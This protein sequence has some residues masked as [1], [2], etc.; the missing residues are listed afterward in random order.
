MPVLESVDSW[1]KLPERGQLAEV[2]RRQW[3]VESV[4]QS[5]RARRGGGQHLVTLESIEEDALGEELRVVWEL[6]PG[7]RAFEKAGLPV[8]D[9]YDSNKSLDA[10]L[11]A[12]RWGAATNVDVDA[13]Q[14]PFRSGV[15]IYAHQLDPLVRALG[16]SR[17]NLLIA[18]DVGFG[19]TV[20][21]GLV[22]QELLLRHRAR[23]V[24][25]VCP[26]SLQIKWR[27]EMLDKFGLEFRVVNTEY[28][29]RLRR[30]RGLRVNP[31]TSYPR[32]ITSMDWAKQGEGLRLL[33]D[34]LPLNQTYPR[35]FDILIV[36]EAHNV[37]PTCS[38]S[39]QV[40]EPS[41]RTELIQRLSPHFNHKLFLT[42]TPHN[43]YQASFAALLELLDDQRFSR[44]VAPSPEKLSRVMTRR[45]KDEISRDDPDGEFQ[46][47]KREL[48]ALEI[49]YTD[50][51]R[52]IH[53]QLKEYTDLRLKSAA[54]GAAKTS[55]EFVNVLLKKRLFSSPRAFLNTLK[56]HRDTLLNPHL[57]EAK[58]PTERI[59]L[60]ALEKTESESEEERE[61]A[62][63]ELLEL[64]SRSVP[65]L[66]PDQRAIL[67]RLI[68]W[69]N[70]ADKGID[71]KAQAILDW[72]EKYIRPGGK[73]GDERV[74]LFTEYLDTYNWLAKILKDAKFVGK[75]GS[76]RLLMIDGSTDPEEREEIKA[77]FQAPPDKDPVR[78][79][80][81]TDAASE[82]IDLQNYC[83]Y[84]I[85]VE[86]PWNPNKME[87]R[88]GRIDRCG[89]KFK[90]VRIWHPVG[91]GFDPDAPWSK[92]GDIVGDGDF[93]ARVAIKVN[94]IR[95]DLGSVGAVVVQQIQDA[96]SGRSLGPLN[97]DG[98]DLKE[99]RQKVAEQLKIEKDVDAK[100]KRLRE[101]AEESR[102]AFR[103]GPGNIARAVDTAL[104]LAKFPPLE[105]IPVPSAKVG[106]VFRDVPYGQ[107]FRVPDLPGSWGRALAG[108]ADP[109][110]GERRPIVF[111]DQYVE[112][113]EDLVLAH[114]NH[115]LV[116][117][118]LRL[119]R[120][121]IWRKDDERRDRLHRV[122]FRYSPQVKP[123]QFAVLVLSRLVIV[124]GDAR[125]IHEEIITSGEFVSSGSFKRIDTQGELKSLLED[126][127]PYENVDTT[128]FEIAKKLFETNEKAIYASVVARSNERFN[129][130][131]PQIE[132]REQREI[133]DV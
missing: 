78:I 96:M 15:H 87:Q 43:G 71:S 23:T 104:E 72:L 86:I 34:V 20:E 91:K 14:A 105:P 82:G 98:D 22:V 68:D 31:W 69:A 106:S 112:N 2:R 111:D 61:E 85:H 77:K 113:R 12:V 32:L 57:K 4:E 133:A 95:K 19:K 29:R 107:A 108:L 10:F 40:A 80:L 52:E 56:K 115:P 130:L 54:P 42:A 118:S 102:A 30:E 60:S 11:D 53:E 17:V 45:M 100:I 51:E 70:K 109:L 47:P 5:S 99:R 62:A 39:N 6:E 25:V 1:N 74:V 76:D 132:K 124:G 84:M 93:L 48:C 24:L 50:Q 36:D 81:A 128:T 120:E 123:G 117:M 88:N 129:A 121:E 26:S 18:D 127:K 33:K 94:Y 35:K 13:M 125:R 97:L 44:S 8:V 55:V 66:E 21:A 16:S 64:N 7:A 37:A 110:T 75:A 67:D 41:K 79:L 9:G 65:S 3:V 38:A 89:Q 114:L 131:R 126:S 101:R 83:R 92:P 119:L 63:N 116:Q 28:L 73:W 49:D 58:R 103:L 59:L 46:L 27:D 122:A 90:T